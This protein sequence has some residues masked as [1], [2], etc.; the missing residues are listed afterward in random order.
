[1][2]PSLDEPTLASLIQVDFGVLQR[3]L[4]AFEDS[5]KLAEKRLVDAE[6]LISSRFL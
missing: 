4:K 1:M 2:A 5:S 3:V 6:V